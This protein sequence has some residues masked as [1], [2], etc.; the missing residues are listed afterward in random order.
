M[1]SDGHQGP[2]RVPG[3]KI[4]SPAGISYM[5]PY[6][7]FMRRQLQS[8]RPMA[9]ACGGTEGRGCPSGQMCVTRRD[10]LGEG[11]ASSWCIG[12]TCN[13]TIRDESKKIRCPEGQQCIRKPNVFITDTPGACADRT[14]SCHSDADCQSTHADD[15]SVEWKCSTKPAG[16]GALCE[17]GESCGLCLHSVKS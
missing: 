17:S 6:R 5:P 7:R 2:A 11:P 3:F 10:V 14:M 1:I 16:D 8:S 12:M 15:T 9:I 4:P 13:H